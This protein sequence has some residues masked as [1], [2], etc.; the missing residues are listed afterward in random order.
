M[1][2]N[3]DSVGDT[4]RIICGS[5][6]ELVPNDDVHLPLNLD[7]GWVC[8]DCRDYQEEHGEFPEADSGQEGLDA[9]A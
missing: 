6:K 9:F 4:P 3:E 7:I 8:S 2:E 5:C 1:A